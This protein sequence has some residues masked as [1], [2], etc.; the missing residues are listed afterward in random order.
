MRDFNNK[1]MELG[2]IDPSNIDLD[3]TSRDDIPQILF[4]LKTIYSDEDLRKKIITIL[5]GLIN[6][7]IDKKNGRPGM[8]W[9]IYEKDLT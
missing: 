2:E 6:D 1:Q 3:L 4:G 9:R 5:N 7:D 8:P